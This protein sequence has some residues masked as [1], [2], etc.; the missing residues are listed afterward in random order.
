M[1]N[2]IEKI[3]AYFE[4]K[5]E[6]VAVYLFGSYAQ[7][8]QGEKSD[9]DIGILFENDDPKSFKEKRNLYM[10]ELPRILRKDIHPVI[11]NL[12]GEELLRQ[13]FLKGK[14]IIVNDKKKFSQYHMIM[15]SKIV[16]FNYYKNQMQTGF[17]KKLMKGHGV[18]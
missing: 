3:K 16:E 17:L 2:L 4:D 10:V 5:G 14:K 1:N 12:A 11:L 6:V 9:I 18:G 15:M 13:I 7:Q 8:K